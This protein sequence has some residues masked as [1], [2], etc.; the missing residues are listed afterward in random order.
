MKSQ[1]HRY[2][3]SAAPTGRARCR[4]C[5]QVVGRGEVRLVTLAVVCERPRRVTKFVRHVSCVDSALAKSVLS[6]SGGDVERVPVVGS[7]DSSEVERVK[8]ELGMLVR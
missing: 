4:A 3:L 1:P 7:V 6:A 2:S 5:K 8:T